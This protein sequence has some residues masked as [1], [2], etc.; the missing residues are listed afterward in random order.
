MRAE[1]HVSAIRY[2][3]CSRSC[4]FTIPV[5]YANSRASCVFFIETHHHIPPTFSMNSYCLTIRAALPCGIL[6]GF[7][8]RGQSKGSELFGSRIFG[9]DN[10]SDESAVHRNLTTV[11][12]PHEDRQDLSNVWN[13]VCFPISRPRAGSTAGRISFLSGAQL[14]WNGRPHSLPWP[15]PCIPLMY[16]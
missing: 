13:M 6:C 11:P 12:A 2:S 7:K 3:F 8:I 16:S 10:T 1:D 9:G 4:W 14:M 5:T 15:W